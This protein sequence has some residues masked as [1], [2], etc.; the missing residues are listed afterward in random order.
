MARKT[1]PLPRDAVIDRMMV[2]INGT[3]SFDPNRFGH[4]DRARSSTT[5]DL[6]KGALTNQLDHDQLF[7][8]DDLKKNV[9]VATGL[10]YYDLRA[11][12]LNLFPTVTPLRNAIPRQ[13]RTNPGDAL[14]YKAVL[15]TIGSGWPYMGWVPEGKRAGSMSYQTTTVTVP[16]VTLG[17]EDS[18]T[19]EARFAAQGF[20]DEDALVQLRLLLR[21]FIKEEAGILGGNAS[22]ALGIPG[23]PVLAVG[24]SGGTLTTATYSVKVVALT[25]E[26]AL[27][28]TPPQ[29]GNA[30]GVATLINIT[31]NDNSSFSLSGGSSN[32]SA[33]QT[34]ALTTGQALTGTVPIVNGAVAYAW[35]IGAIGA[36]T[37]QQITT[38]NSFT[39]SVPL[40]AGQ[41]AQSAVTVDNSRNASLAFDGV[42]TVGYNNG[43][44]ATPNAYVKALATGT[45]GIGSF[46]TPSGTGGVVEINNMLVF[47]WTNFKISPTVGYVNAQELNNITVKVLSTSSA[48]LLRYNVQADDAGLP[49]YKL[50]ASGVV[51][52]Y[53]NP[54]TADGGMRIPI[55]IHPNLAA[56]T[57]VWWAEH[58]P[59]WYVSNATPEVA[60]M[61]TRQDY[62]AEVW[63]KT[64]RAQF[65]GIYVQEALA[66][67]APFGTGIITNIGNG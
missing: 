36:E 38:I 10:V 1:V 56:G 24:G 66:V 44:L 18:L 58:L 34:I 13:Q 41:Q 43:A 22:L 62:Y 27:N 30:A 59:P 11:P 42:L 12:A 63:P 50:T 46:L 5:L 15:A 47:M 54:Y 32:I 31:G 28:S 33:A 65:Y 48:P 20:E 26:G 14:H 52:F 21:M 9:T 51:A 25:Q 49:E 40:L 19:E 6:F 29:V 55:K 53:F 67:F 35:F 45:A 16:Y 57:M 7:D 37:L 8:G 17:E 60:V 61:Q 39:Q 23:T 2:T 3:Q 64:T 4:M